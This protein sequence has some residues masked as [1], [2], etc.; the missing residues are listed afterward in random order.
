MTAVGGFF[1][2]SEPFRT[3]SGVSSRSYWC[4]FEHGAGARSGSGSPKKSGNDVEE[5]NEQVALPGLA[6]ESIKKKK[7]KKKKPTQPTIRGSTSPARVVREEG[8]G[9][10][11]LKPPPARRPTAGMRPGQAKFVSQRSQV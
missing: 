1:F 3:A 8:V 5:P 2:D 10:G 4:K 11:T 9:S 7:K 6:D